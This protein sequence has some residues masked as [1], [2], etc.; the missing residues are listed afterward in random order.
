M[1]INLVIL[2]F[3]TNKKSIYVIK[4]NKYENIYETV[5]YLLYI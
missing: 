5:K 2:C 4:I 1:Y 3:G